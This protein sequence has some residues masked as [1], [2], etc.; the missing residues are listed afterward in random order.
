MPWPGLLVLPA[1]QQH[2]VNVITR[3]VDYGGIFHDDVKPGHTFDAQD[4]RAFRPAG[5]VEAGNEKLNQLRPLCEK[6]GVTMLQLAC[7]WNLSQPAVRSV[8]PTL[9]QEVAPS[10]KMIE[11]KVDE[12]A[13]FPDVK[14]TPDD[15]ERIAH[16]GDNKGCMQLKGANRSHTTTPEPDKWG[17]APDLESVGRR[18]GIDPDRD[19]AY[20]HAEAKMV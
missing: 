6:Y 4:H 10:T 5:W 14:L 8:I 15:V 13:A 2:D 1:A 18:W 7:L 3:V 17:F 16:I 11:S 12:L 9:M 20:T 19:L